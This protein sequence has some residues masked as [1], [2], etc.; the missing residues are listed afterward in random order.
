MKHSNKKS[1]EK[2]LSSHLDSPKF[3][4]LGG[5]SSRVEQTPGHLHQCLVRCVLEKQGTPGR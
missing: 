4:E 3:S 2:I 1:S 5:C